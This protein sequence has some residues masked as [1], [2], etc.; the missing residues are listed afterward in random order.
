MLRRLA[1]R[2]ICGIASADLK[3]NGRFVV[4]TGESG[5]GKSSLVRSLELAA[6]KRSNNAL[7]RS[8]SV[9]GEVNAEFSFQGGVINIRRI[10]SSEGKNRIFMG[11]EQVNLSDLI[12]TLDNRI[13][14]QSQFSHLCLLDED[15]FMEILD[16]FGGSAVRSLRDQMRSA[17][18]D[19]RDAALEFERLKRDFDR[20]QR[21]Q[22]IMEPL[23]AEL[24]GL[25]PFP[26][27]AKIWETEAEQIRRSMQELRAVEEALDMLHHRDGSATDIINDALGSLSLRLPG[28]DKKD[29]VTRRLSEALDALRGAIAGLKTWEGLSS[30][31]EME[32]KAG[33]LEDKLGTLKRLMRKLHLDDDQD[34]VNFLS[35]VEHRSQWL[36]EAESRLKSL[37]ERVAALKKRAYE[38]AMK[39]RNTRASLA[40]SFSREVSL[41]LEDLGMEGVMFSVST[42]P[43]KKIGPLGAD[44]V[45]FLMGAEGSDLYPIS[46]RASGGELSRILLA[47]QCAMKGRWSPECIVFDEVEAGLGG[48]S[49]LLAGL[50]L[51]E[52]S[53]ASQVILITH[54]ATLAAMGDQHLVV[55]R[56]EDLTEV[57][58]VSE[59]D[60]VAEIARMLSG[61]AHEDA[62]RHARFLIEKYGGPVAKVD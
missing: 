18:G 41:N 51:K 17:Y 4:I 6:G 60:R 48:K 13:Q 43:L 16:S 25:N 35:E 12:L 1:V 61:E 59:E 26:G 21:D 49:A 54:E 36:I 53:N 52:L 50:K 11:G 32:A 55:K 10:I 56:R 15:A 22:A 38:T 29:E 62:L 20:Y 42:E 44:R 31:D 47:I 34:V 19:A 3:I 14:I 57:I 28:S 39:L 45:L 7:I 8:S 2:N 5:S 27:C 23:V 30:V 40:E 9:S 24:R 33:E 58:E 37:R 46:K